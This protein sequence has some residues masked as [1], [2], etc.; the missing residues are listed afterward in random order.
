LR[1][2][3][4]EALLACWVPAFDAACVCGF[5]YRKDAK[6]AKDAKEVRISF[7]ALFAFLA[8]LR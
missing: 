2:W 7:L 5:F 8:S 1:E 4:M 6:N 3:F